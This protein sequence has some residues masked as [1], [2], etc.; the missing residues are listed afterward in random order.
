MLPFNNYKNIIRMNIEE[1]YSRIVNG[2]YMSFTS[3]Y[4][5]EKSYEFIRKKYEEEP[6]NH[7][8]LNLMG[9]VNKFIGNIDEAIKYYK[10]AIDKG[11]T[12]AIGNL[13]YVYH[14]EQEKKDLNEA[15][16]YYKMAIDKGLPD[17]MNNLGVL[18]HYELA[19]QDFDEAIK[20]YK[21]AFDNGFIFALD[22]IINILMGNKEL[23]KK[24]MTLFW[25]LET[26]KSKLETENSK[27][28]EYITELEYMPG[29][30]GY[31]EAKEHFESYL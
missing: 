6:E 15:I 11:N 23:L 27:L 12:Y 2:E 22:E 21:M 25:K 4:Q 1:F 29:G 26:E 5:N 8:N 16:K 14:K 30:V 9:I 19:K 31:N 7:V 13:A 10:M 20:Y 18:Y 28:E 3:E 24:Y 17:S